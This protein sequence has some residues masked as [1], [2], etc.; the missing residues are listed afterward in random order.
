MINAPSND[1]DLVTFCHRPTHLRVDD[2]AW[3]TFVIANADSF[4]P[5]QVKQ[6]INAMLT[7]WIW[8]PF[9][10]RSSPRPAI[11]WRFFHTAER[12]L[13]GMLQIPL[14]VTQDDADASAMVNP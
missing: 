1:I 11:G 12:V 5:N 2:S 8:I 6:H 13:E 3:R 4:V 7:L 9:P 10:F 14:D